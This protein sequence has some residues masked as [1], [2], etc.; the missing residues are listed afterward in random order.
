MC[1]LCGW[2]S[3]FGVFC[4]F[5]ALVFVAAV[6]VVVVRVVCA[7]VRVWCFSG[8]F[9]ACPQLS[10]LGLEALCGC[11]GCVLWSLASPC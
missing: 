2:C 7:R 5:V 9:V 11:G 1:L 8:V 6:V 4:V 3:R 10:G